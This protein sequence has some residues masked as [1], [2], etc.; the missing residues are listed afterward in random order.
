MTTRAELTT[1]IAQLRNEIT[2]TEQEVRDFEK[3]TP[4]QELATEIHSA[5]CHSI[6]HDD[7]ICMWGYEKKWDAYSHAINLKK[8]NRFSMLLILKRQLKLLNL[9][10]SSD[11]KDQRW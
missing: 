10:S 8:R 9:L 7:G 3:L 11:Y 1:K 5:F 6:T 2:K 4:A